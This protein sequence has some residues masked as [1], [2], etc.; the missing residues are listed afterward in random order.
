MYLD[1][2]KHIILFFYG[3]M[4]CANSHCDVNRQKLR[5]KL[6]KSLLSFHYNLLKRVIL[7]VEP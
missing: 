1:S 5:F 7:V 3:S 6:D 4:R 2:G